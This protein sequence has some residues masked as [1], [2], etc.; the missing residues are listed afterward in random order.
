ME[1]VRDIYSIIFFFLSFLLDNERKQFL[2]KISFCECS[3]FKSYAIV[4]PIFDLD[5]QNK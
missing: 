4:P 1:G 3:F 5:F 2:Q